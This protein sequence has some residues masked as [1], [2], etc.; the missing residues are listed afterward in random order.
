M[1][2]SFVLLLILAFAAGYGLNTLVESIGIEQNKTGG[3]VSKAKR[4]NKIRNDEQLNL[5]QDKL[6]NDDDYFL[7]T[8]DVTAFLLSRANTLADLT[9]RSVNQC[10]GIEELTEQVA[11]LKSLNL[12]ASN[13]E[14]ALEDIRNGLDR[15]AQGKDVPDYDQSFNNAL[16]GFFR[17]ENQMDFGKSFVEAAGKYLE[18]NENAELAALVSDW[19]IFSYQDAKLNKSEND[20]AYWDEKYKEMSNNATE[21][22]NQDALSGLN[23][24]NEVADGLILNSLGIIDMLQVLHLDFGTTPDYS[25]ITPPQPRPLKRDTLI[26]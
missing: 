14:L 21:G 17:I 25:G 15:M 2:K 11:G 18:S 24:L 26:Y 12:K 9:K 7:Q 3:D 23:D 4:Y 19:A 1:K 8:K 16:A 10:S 6:Q 13:T 22:L 5:L 20:M